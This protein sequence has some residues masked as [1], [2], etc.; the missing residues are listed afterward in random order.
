MLTVSEALSSRNPPQARALRGAP[1]FMTPG[2]VL[3]RAFARMVVRSSDEQLR[4]LASGWR[5]R[6]ILAGIL[7]QMPRRLDRGKASAVHAVANWKITDGAGGGCDRFQVRIEDGRCRVIRRPEGPAQ[8]T[9]EL[10]GVDF[11]RLVAGVADGAELFM[12][13]KLRI[14]GDLVLTARL[15]ALFRFATRP[16]ER[17]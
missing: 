13:G 3:A 4:W 17:G 12:I 15:P 1:R 7:R 11:L 5:R 8:V 9:L 2:D 16:P 6:L 10:D 14:E